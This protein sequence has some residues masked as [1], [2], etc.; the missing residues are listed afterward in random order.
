[1][2][3]STGILTIDLTAIQSNWRYIRSQLRAPA[4]ASAVIKADA[5]GL[6]AERVGPALYT[7]GC[8]EFFLAT[9]EEA[10]SARKYLPEDAVIYVL[11]GVRSHSEALCIA[12][13]LVPVLFSLED[14]RRWNQA[15]ATAGMGMPCALKLDTGMTRL[16]M[17]FGEL[18]ELCNHPELL[19]HS[20]PTLFMSHLA[21]ADEPEHSLN[22]RQF[23]AFEQ[24]AAAI[25]MIFPGV[26]LSLAN[27]SGI[28]LGPQW[29]LD[30]VRPGGGHVTVGGRPATRRPGGGRITGRSRPT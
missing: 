15:C 19:E 20:P 1:M 30:L 4:Q 16:G 14:I 28:F 26:R 10:L 12:A 25:K 7:A 13:R 2:N 17:S 11:G 6:G 8:R 27:S 21:C 18:Q 22:N 24:A 9:L 5:Y 29:H 23:A 3:S